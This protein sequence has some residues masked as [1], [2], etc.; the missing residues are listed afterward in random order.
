MDPV[1][2]GA[3]GAVFAQNAARAAQIRAF[4][5]FGA[6]AGMAPDLDVFISSDTDPLLFL[7]YH[8]HFTHALVFIP[9]GA[10]IVCAALFKLLRHPLTFPTAYLACLIGY[11]T[12]GLLDAC[13]S[14]GTQLLWPF[15][16]ARIAW[17]NVSVIDPLCTVPLLICVIAAARSR[18]RRYAVIGLVWLLSYL[19][20]GLFQHHRALDAGEAV[21]QLRGHEAAR[22]TAKPSFGNL[23]VWKSIYEADGHYYVD[24]VRT[25]LNASVCP[26]ERIPKLDLQRDLPNLD[27]DSQ[28]AIDIE[29]FRWFSDD[30]L[31]I[32]DKPGYVIDI[33]YAMVPNEIRPLWGIHVDTAAGP[34]Q[35]V[36]FES[37]R[38]ADAGQIQA[39]WQQ[40]RGEG[41]AILP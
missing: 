9:V 12:H 18:R 4:A 13:T 20:V 2:Q 10:L 37:A 29:R 27:P 3:V 33:R 7:E 23:L 8:R 17:N 31:A 14:Y 6:L 11:A 40:I 26:G 35:H 19:L 36:R 1:S 28:Q 30:Y 21:A 41:C 32:Y 38:R 22:L 34:T 16:D 5:L 15:S 25:G 24:A 39:F